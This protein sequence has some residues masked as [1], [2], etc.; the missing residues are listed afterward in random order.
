MFLSECDF[1]KDVSTL[2]YATISEIVKEI[3]KKQAE[4]SSDSKNKHDLEL[5]Q[6]KLPTKIKALHCLQTIRNYL[7]SISEITD[8]DYNSFIV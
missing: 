5:K 4:I 3:K 1:Y 2:P 6:N 7:T 8:S